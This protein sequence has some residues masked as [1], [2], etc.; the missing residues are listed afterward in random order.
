MW[1]SAGRHRERTNRWQLPAIWLALCFLLLAGCTST[2]SASARYRFPACTSTAG[3]TCAVG[4]GATRLQVFVE[5]DDGV[6]PIT[7]AIRAAQRSIWIEVYILSDTTVI[8]ALEDAAN[9]GLDVRV[10]LEPHPYE[11]SPVTVQSTLEKLKAAGIKV[12][13]TNPIFQLTHAKFL[14]LDGTTLFL[15]TANLSHAALGGT[16]QVRNREYLLEDFE[17]AD[18][19][20][21]QTIFT[22]DWNRATPTLSDPNLLVSP[23]NA[24]VKLLALISSAQTSIQIENEEM[25]DT[26]LEN[27]LAQAAQRGV[28][29][30]VVLPAPASGQDSNAAGVALLRK[31]GITV[32]YNTQYYI[33][34]KLMLIDQIRAYVGSENIS[35]A[36]LD[37]NRELGLIVADPATLKTLATTF[38]SDYATSQVYA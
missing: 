3:P 15:L 13:E 16:P 24:R 18:V 28:S 35:T 5:P 2:S 7:D 12:N 11:S 14:L 31:A 25:Q 36:S 1:S 21:A 20:E 22:S 27:A 30:Q 8:T 23:I 4:T 37:N 17:T 26:Q 38:S 32:R 6:R 29:I 33:H 34:A 10:M 9:R 19:N